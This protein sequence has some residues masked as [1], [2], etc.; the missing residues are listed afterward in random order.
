MNFI[1]DNAYGASPEILEA[2]AKAA[3]GAAVSY[4]E[5]AWTARVEARLAEIFEHEVA[6]FP[7]VT[8]TAANSLILSQLCPPYGAV[9]CHE[10]SHI[11]VDECGAPEFF[12]GGAKLGLLQ[13]PSAKITPDSVVKGLGQFASGVHSAKPAVVSITQATEFGTVYRPDEIAALAEA[14]HGRGLKLH[15]DGA[16]FAN[17]LAALNCSP[18]EAT[19]KAGVDALAFGASKNGALMAEAAVFFRAEDARDFA[20][21]RKRAGQLVSKMRFVSAQ[22]EAYLADDLWLKTATRA[23]ALANRLSDGLSKAPGVEIAHPTQANTVFA[24]MPEALAKRL[25]DAG[26]AF[27]D[28]ERENGRV[29]AR[30]VCSF[31]TPEADVERL[32]ETASR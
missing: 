7:V 6:V 23:N 22:F 19:W 31:A 2:V 13:G 28:W 21:R 32:L 27:Y 24:W 20:Y 14:A 10:K 17:A 15:M 9:L 16:R 25:H 29:M 18:A 5:D 11:A 30:L 3:A 4:G 12:S 1:S 8:G 26:F